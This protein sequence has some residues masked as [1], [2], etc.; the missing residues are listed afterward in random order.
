MLAG[1]T[2]ARSEPSPQPRKAIAFAPG[3]QDVCDFFLVTEFT[4][5]ATGGTSEGGVDRVL[6]TD[7]FGIMRN[8][9]ESRAV[10]VSVD[11]HLAEGA[12]R[13]TPTVRF[14]QWFAGRQSVD[15]LVGYAH[16]SLEQEGV[17]GPVVDVRYSP[18]AWFH[19]QAGGCRIRSV[20]S[21]FYY[22][23]YQVHEKSP[24]KIHVGAGLGGAP[25]A[26]SWG[27]QAI[28]FAGLLYAFRNM[29]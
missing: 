18:T 2:P 29:D 27:L 21:I 6:F 9:G 17:V 26:V 7:A 10:G 14:K 13:F 24:Y 3:R 1:A 12:I 20:S 8:I 25:G 4:A 16:A 22:P 11:T 5:S 15:L 23:D 19:V 28:A